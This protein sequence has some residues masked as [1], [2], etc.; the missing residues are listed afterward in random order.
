VKAKLALIVGAGAGY[1]LGT[2]DGRQRYEQ[3]KAKAQTLWEDPKVQEQVN[4]VTPDKE[5][6]TSGGAD[7]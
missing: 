1:V 7:V 4:R 3:L 2:R 5:A 6:T